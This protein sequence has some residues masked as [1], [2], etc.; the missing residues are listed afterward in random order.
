MQVP[1]YDREKWVMTGG[2]S[3][4]SGGGDGGVDDGVGDGWALSLV[5]KDSKESSP[6][7][8]RKVAVV[9]EGIETVELQL[10]Q[11][12][13]DTVVNCSRRSGTLWS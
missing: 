11:R 10:V 5:S 12:S 2:V 8:I 4:A 6:V 7:G 13:S 9:A 3:E 1:R